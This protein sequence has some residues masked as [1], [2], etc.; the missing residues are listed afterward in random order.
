MG[1]P[2]CPLCGSDSHRKCFSLRGWDLLNCGNCRLFFIEPY[3]A[4]IAA[5]P[6]GREPARRAVSAQ[7]QRLYDVQFYKVHMGFIDRWCR[8]AGSVL[9]V[10]CG[11][12]LL[13]ERLGRYGHLRRV[14]IEPAADLAE[15]A[16][17]W[18]GCEIHHV[19]IERFSSDGRF[20]VITLINVLSHIRPLAGLF[21]S[22]RSLLAGGGK[23]IIKTGELESG[24]RR[25]D[26]RDWSLG[27]HLHFLGIG[28]MDYI[29][30]RYGF[31]I[32][33]H[34][35]RSYAQELFSRESF[36]TPGKTPARR[37]LKKLIAAVPPALPMLAKC[38]EL[39]HG[40]R[41]WSSFIVLALGR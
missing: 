35:R 32:L 13:L 10:G 16:R 27:Q 24:V 34:E 41:V 25:G 39:K 28:T 30:R 11:T 19:P 29:C 5:S 12:G 1:R 31:E 9:D 8:G 15:F 18:A 33:A 3:P 6:G 20:D 14:G 23:V 38:Y 2:A 22:L 17:R 40:R 37:M 21:E 4:S 26:V 36:S 7:R